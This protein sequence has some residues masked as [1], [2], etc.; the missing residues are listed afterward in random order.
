VVRGVTDEG[1]ILCITGNYIAHG[2]RARASD[3]VT[4]ELG[5]Q[6]KLEVQ[7]KLGGEVNQDRFTRLYQTLLDQAQ[8]GRS[9]GQSYLVRVNRH[10]PPRKAQ[11]HAA[12]DAR[13]GSTPT[14]GSSRP[15]SWSEQPPLTIARATSSSSSFI[16]WVGSTVRSPPR[17]PPGLIAY[18]SADIVLKPH[19]WVLGIGSNARAAPDR[20]WP[21]QAP[22]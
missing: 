18:W 7:Q 4:R 15:I 16:L 8:N 1:K 10:L 14:I 17:P 12:G 9:P 22:R 19:P 11:S 5:R 3:L 20:S 21:G 13:R 6:S 2:I